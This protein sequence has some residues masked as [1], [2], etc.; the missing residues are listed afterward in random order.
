MRMEFELMCD[1]RFTNAPY[2]WERSKLN[3]V[4]TYQ[5]LKVF[6][7]AQDGIRTRTTSRSADFKSA[8]SAVPPLGLIKISGPAQWRPTVF[9]TG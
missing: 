5:S 6:C 1:N 3:L 9:T 8:V 4:R 2:Y 7:G